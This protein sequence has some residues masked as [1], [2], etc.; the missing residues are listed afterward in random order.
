MANR[1]Q[2][3]VVIDGSNVARS[4]AWR[5]AWPE[6]DDSLRY[7]R[8]VDTVA[9]W[10]AG[11]DDEVE[12][13]FDGAGTLT[14][15]ASSALRVVHAHREGAADADELIERHIMQAVAERRGCELVSDDR[16]IRN[17]VA[18]RID[19]VEGSAGFVARL[20][21]RDSALDPARSVNIEPPVERASK[22]FDGVDDAVRA[23]LERM[24]RGQ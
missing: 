15:G 11:S 10:A 14:E 3:L 18:G 22:L 2:R 4:A 23:Q 8:L 9:S 19:R 13:V 17:A 12:I 7:A 24:R 20:L 16:G 6:L 1:L 21:G 5:D